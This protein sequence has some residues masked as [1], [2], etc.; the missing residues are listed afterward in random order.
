MPLSSIPS[1]SSSTTVH[2]SVFEQVDVFDVREN[3]RAVVLACDWVGEIL[4]V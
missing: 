2:V 3:E 1:S 4:D